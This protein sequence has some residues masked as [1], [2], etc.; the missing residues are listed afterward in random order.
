[1]KPAVNTFYLDKGVQSSKA[2]IKQVT[3]ARY[4]EDEN[5][6]RNDIAAVSI[7]MKRVD[8]QNIRASVWACQNKLHRHEAEKCKGSEEK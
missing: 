2:N 3:H 1:M 4:N 5:W 8:S 6:K 7:R